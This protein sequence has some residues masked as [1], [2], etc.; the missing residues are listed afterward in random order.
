MMDFELKLFSYK[1]RK[2]KK[3]MKNLKSLKKAMLFLDKLCHL[4]SLKSLF[5]KKRYNL[6]I[7]KCY[8]LS[9][10]NLQTK[11]DFYDLYDLGSIWREFYLLKLGIWSSWA[12]GFF[13]VISI[14]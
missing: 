1:F 7:F 6:Q 10:L 13:M 11:K 12:V 5:E 3:N 4:H 2:V 9:F 14:I 8:N